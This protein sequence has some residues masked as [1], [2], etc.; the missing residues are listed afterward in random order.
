MAQVTRPS[1]RERTS[2]VPHR[3]Q[4]FVYSVDIGRMRFRVTLPERL[5]A[6][7]ARRRL[8]EM[9]QRNE[10]VGPGGRPLLADVR[11]EGRSREAQEYNGRPQNARLDVFR[12]AYLQST[13]RRGQFVP[14]PDVRVASLMPGKAQPRRKTGL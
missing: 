4:R 7:G 2:P 9:L 8:F 1:V 14:A 10:L 13:S 11:M 3:I 5:P 12:D 6:R